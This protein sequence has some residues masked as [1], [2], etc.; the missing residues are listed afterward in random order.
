MVTGM[1]KVLTRIAEIQNKFSPATSNAKPEEFEIALQNAQERQ[2][3]SVIKRRDEFVKTN[4][5]S[6]TQSYEKGS[7][8][9]MLVDA[10]EKHGVDSKLVLAL[11][12]AESGY[13]SDAVSSAGAVGVMQLMPDTA[14]GLGITDSFDA[15][16]NIDGGVRYLKQM[17]NM[18]GG[19]T[20][21]ALAAYNAG[22]GAVQKYGGIPPYSETQ[23]YVK[24]ILS[25]I[26]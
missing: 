5:T 17:L 15:K 2:N 11:A 22:P 23:A 21:K 14:R 19:D 16:Q 8:K 18:F 26:K 25:D 1:N 9:Q 20:T 3:T 12:N 24:N 4:N 13:R 10:A 6:L 7:I